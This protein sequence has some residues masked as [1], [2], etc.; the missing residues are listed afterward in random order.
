MN[1]V[2]WYSYIREG[3]QIFFLNRVL[4]RLTPALFNTNYG[5]AH[6]SAVKR[7]L[8]YLRK[9]RSLKLVYSRSE[10]Q[11]LGFSDSDWGGDKKDMK[12]TTG[13]AFILIGAAVSWNSKKQPTVAKSSTEAVAEYMHLAWLQ[14]K[15]F[16]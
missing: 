8:R 10:D 15:L 7:I 13:S 11:L 16:G 2:G 1:S 6:W 4:L 5:R 3:P 9:T 12:S 14:V